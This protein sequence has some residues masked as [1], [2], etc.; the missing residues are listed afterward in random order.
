VQSYASLYDKPEA[1]FGDQISPEAAQRQFYQ[2][3]QNPG[4]SLD[5]FADR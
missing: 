1:R 4:E 2:A 3:F 5:D